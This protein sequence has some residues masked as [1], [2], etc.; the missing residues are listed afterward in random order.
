MSQELLYHVRLKLKQ[1]DV[2]NIEKDLNRL[3]KEREVKGSK[4]QSKQ[5]KEQ[6]K[7]LK[8]QESTLKALRNELKQYKE[9]LADAQLEARNQGQ[10][11][12]SN[13]RTQRELGT[14][15]T[16]VKNQI[17]S[18]TRGNLDYDSALKNTGGS[19]REM[20]MSLRAIKI[21]ID[22]VDDPMGKGATRVAELT[23]EHEALNASIGG[24]EKSMGVHTRNVGN[25]EGSL[26]SLANTIAIVQGPLGPLAGRINSAATAI[27]RWRDANLLAAGS[28][29]T[30]GVAVRAGLVASGIGV[31]IVALTSLLA[32]FRRTEKGQQAARVAAAGL[33]AIFETLADVAVR[34]GE[35][36]YNAFQ[37]PQESLQRLW[38]GV[39]NFGQTLADDLVGR[40]RAIPD[41]F[42]GMTDRVLGSFQLLGA[43]IKLALADV[44]IIGGNID[45]EK[46]EQ[47]LKD[48][49]I[50]ILEGVTT[51]GKAM[52]TVF[53]ATFAKDLFAGAVEGAKAFGAELK[54]NFQE[55]RR[56]AREMND[57]LVRE[58]DLLVERARMERDT[59]RAREMSRDLDIEEETRL[60]AILKVRA[61]EEEMLQK[62]L[63][64]ER[65]RLRVMIEQDDRFSS[66]EEQLREVA[67]QR[68]KI[69]KLEEENAKKMM[70]LTRDQMAV[71]R[72]L[73]ERN[74]R[75][76][77]LDFDTRM[78]FRNIE[79]ET[80]AQQLE[81]MGRMLEAER[82]RQ[83]ESEAELA[84]RKHLRL[85]QL[86]AEFINQKFSA[87]KSAQLAQNQ[88]ELEEAERLLEA[89]K[90]LK[91]LER[92]AE[93]QKLAAISNLISASNK[94]FFGES[95]ALSVA[96]TIIDTY[97]GIQKALAA[98]P[99]FPFNA[100]NAAAVA[101]Q[102]IAN[103]RRIMS[104][105]L[106]STSADSSAGQ[107]QAPTQSFGFVDLPS[108][109]AEVA[110][111]QAPER[112]MQPN[113]IL[114]GEFDPEFLSVKVRQGS[115]KISGNTLGI[116][117]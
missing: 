109:G 2:K 23:A 21:A 22:E 17:E 58:R 75:L 1:G 64:L 81:Q 71:E 88:W 89:K 90:R 60:E 34:L 55:N 7:E 52:R 62:E 28:A 40:V 111:Q 30:L 97:A 67:E 93:Q 24:V 114:E 87:E 54:S 110:S 47:Q 45:T 102:G 107:V 113:I 78:G 44:P 68:A 51:T 61:Q 100:I 49:N 8:E 105:Q 101:A 33:R 63:Q 59:A 14:A 99:G 73:R 3:E 76:A 117:I 50:R 116:G 35:G 98:P 31:L 36:M 86:E 56:N 79:I 41:V 46:A 38:V 70:S 20:K 16:E 37:N 4:G 69:F 106:G 53:D 39:K 29:K 19:L 80:Q 108:L 112:D 42:R 13:I 65:D 66:T 32:F 10:A 12:E 9:A 15:I 91:D 74:M 26:R 92:Q 11:T 72:Q 84:E 5:I 96:S 104:T 57:I 27:S 95:K 85:Q 25:Y 94:A 77:R 103:V 43:H 18:A 115:D 82:L 48:A 83:A 6:N